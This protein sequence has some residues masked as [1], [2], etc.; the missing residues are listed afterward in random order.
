MVHTFFTG[1]Q[2]LNSDVVVA[3]QQVAGA[4]HYH[5]HRQVASQNSVLFD[6]KGLVIKFQAITNIV[7][8]SVIP[9]VLFD[10]VIGQCSAANEQEWQCH[11]G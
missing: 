4:V 3:A 10:M 2:R 11:G 7:S 9:L 1:G 8:V 6:G 5:C